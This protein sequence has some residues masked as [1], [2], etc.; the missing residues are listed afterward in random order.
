MHLEKIKAF[1]QTIIGEDTIDAKIDP[2]KRASLTEVEN[3]LHE[4]GASDYQTK[5]VL[6]IIQ[7][8]S[9][10][11]NIDKKQ[12]LSFLGQIVQDADR[13]DALGAIGTAR[14]FYYG[15]SKQHLIYDDTRPRKAEE[16]TEENYREQK[17][18]VNHF[19][20]NLLGLKDC[21]N[22]KMG[23]QL[24]KH[25]TEFMEQFLQELFDEIQTV[26]EH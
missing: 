11:K 23:R 1:A 13:L 19:Y 2:E 14:A 5:E 9:Y 20:E 10:S 24:A 4:S 3:I 26:D 17:S 21:M 6:Y 16:I 18:V 8:L 7:N 15:G 25:R 12:T 22:T